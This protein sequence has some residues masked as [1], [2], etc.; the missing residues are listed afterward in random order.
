MD[1]KS[2][3]DKIAEHDGLLICPICGLPFKPYRKSQKTCGAD[4]CKKLHHEAYV[5]EYVRKKRADDP[6]AYRAYRREAMRRYRA[7]QRKIKER[8]KQLEEMGSRWEQQ[9]LFS[10][11]VKEYGWRYGDVQ[12]QKT[13]D[14]VPKIDVNLGGFHDNLH[15][16]NH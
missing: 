9:E 2:L 6:D 13:L 4:E 11:K 8:D 12:A 3:K 5:K 7:K 15:N 14:S 10:E 1:L 16:K